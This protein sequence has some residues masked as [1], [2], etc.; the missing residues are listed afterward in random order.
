MYFRWRKLFVQKCAPQLV[1]H[2]EGA[3]CVSVL[4]YLL[5]RWWK[6][7]GL[8]SHVQRVGCTL[9]RWLILPELSITQ[10]QLGLRCRQN[11]QLCMSF[12]PTYRDQILTKCLP[13]VLRPILSD[14][15]QKKLGSH[16]SKTWLLGLRKLLFDQFSVE[17]PFSRAWTFF[18]SVI[19]TYFFVKS[20]KEWVKEP[21]VNIC[22]WSDNYKW[23]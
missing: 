14:F 10:Y 6:T 20:H 23:V 8:L 19:R 17:Y 7:S 1:A 4:W 11:M 13:R 16:H 12:G 2:L 15:L 22:L 9:Y 18:L 5:L 3:W 21:L